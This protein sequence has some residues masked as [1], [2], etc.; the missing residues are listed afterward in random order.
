M[1]AGFRGR[2]RLARAHLDTLGDDERRVEADAELADEL[3]RLLL[4]AGQRAEEFRG[5]RAGDGAEVGDGL[6]ARHADA[7]VA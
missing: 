2:A 5:A 3:R 6:G 4:I 1:H 7:V